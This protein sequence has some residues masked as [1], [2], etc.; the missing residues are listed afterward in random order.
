MQSKEFNKK[1]GLQKRMLC[2]LSIKTWLKTPQASRSFLNRSRSKL[3]KEKRK[4]IMMKFHFY[5][6]DNLVYV[7]SAI[8]HDWIEAC[9]IVAIEKNVDENSILPQDW[10]GL[11]ACE[12]R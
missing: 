4:S 2:Q 10:L 7:G 12:P 5:T 6:F 1:L 8:A 3:K 9:K 11:S